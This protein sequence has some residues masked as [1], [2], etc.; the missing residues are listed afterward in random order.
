MVVS[1]MLMESVKSHLSVPWRDG[2]RWG[3]TFP[4]WH[5]IVDCLSSCSL[6]SC[7]R[8]LVSWILL[9][10]IFMMDFGEKESPWL[11]SSFGL[12]IMDRLKAMVIRKMIVI[13]IPKGFNLQKLFNFWKFGFQNKRSSVFKFI[14]V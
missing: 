1:V 3:M 5:G 4:N 6:R 14:S 9:I 2:R 10:F 8:F 7:S 11:S 13:E 12:L